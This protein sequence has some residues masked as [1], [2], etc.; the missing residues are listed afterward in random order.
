MDKYAS[1][2]PKLTFQYADYRLTKRTGKQDD[3]A[4]PKLNPFG[5]LTLPI[6]GKSQGM[7]TPSQLEVL[8]FLD[9]GAVATCNQYV[10]QG[11]ETFA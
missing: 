5:S 10:G 2:N 8:C 3:G 9:G 4:D 11:V 6:G 7:D 1:Q